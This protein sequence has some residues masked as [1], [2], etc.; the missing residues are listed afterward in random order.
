MKIKCQMCQKMYKSLTKEFL[1]ASCHLKKYGTW[2][3][4]FSAGDKKT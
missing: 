2:S 1:C 4:E 3:Q